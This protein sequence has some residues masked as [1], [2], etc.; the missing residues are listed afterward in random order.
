MNMFSIFKKDLITK[1]DKLYE[2]KLGE[3]CMSN[4]KAI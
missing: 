1:L 3:T 2:S 4:V